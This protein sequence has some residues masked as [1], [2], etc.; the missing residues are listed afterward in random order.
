MMLITVASA[1]GYALC[2]LSTPS[3]HAIPLESKR[4]RKGTSS[5]AINKNK[6]N[7]IKRCR[8]EQIPLHF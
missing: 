8:C 4:N 7:F 1:S 3:S 2:C 6:N 5:T